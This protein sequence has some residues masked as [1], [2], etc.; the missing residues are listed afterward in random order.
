MNTGTFLGDPILIL[1]EK[2]I[3]AS[4]EIEC[5]PEIHKTGTHTQKEGG[6]EPL[7]T[8]PLQRVRGKLG[9]M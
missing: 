1:P 3:F 8:A 9:C 6:G 5:Y 2:V 7:E 4:L